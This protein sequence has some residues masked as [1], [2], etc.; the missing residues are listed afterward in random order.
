LRVTIE[1]PTREKLT[2]RLSGK[3]VV[4]PPVGGGSGETSYGPLET[5]VPR[6]ESVVAFGGLASGVWSHEIAVDS[7]GQL[8]HQGDQLVADDGEPALIW[9]RVFAS[10]L[11]V[12]EPDDDGDG[13]CDATC[14]LRD[15][16]ETANGL[17][18]ATLIVFDR[19]AFGGGTV[20]ITIDDP[21]PLLVEAPSLAIDGTD[22]YGRPFQLRPFDQRTY[23]TVISLISGAGEPSED[24]YCPCRE[25][26]AGTFRVRAPDVIF[27]GLEIRRVLPAE[28]EIC[29]G[30]Q[31]LIN[32]GLGSAGSLIQ[33]CRFDGGASAVT[34]AE[35]PAG[36]TGPATGKDC[37][38]SR[39]TE[40]PLDDPVLVRDSE[41]AYCMDRGVKSEDGVM[42]I[43]TSWIHNNLRGGAFA[44]ASDAGYGVFNLGANLFEQNGLN[45]PNE[46]PPSCGGGQVLARPNASEVS[47]Q[48][49][50]T[51]IAADAN[52]LR[53]GALQ[54]LYFQEASIGLLSNLYV[55]GINNADNGKGILI[56]RH[57][58]ASGDVLIRGT[59]VV[60]NDDA[61]VKV[62]D[63]VGAD[64]GTGASPGNNAFTQNGSQPRRDLIDTEDP[65]TPSPAR[66][67]QWSAC[68]DGMNPDADVCFVQE[69]SDQ[70]TN[71]DIG[72][73]NLF[74]VTE[75]QPH[76]SDASVEITSVAPAKAV[77]G[78]VVRVYGA[79]FDAVS[80]HSGGVNGDCRDLASGNTCQPLQG[81]CVEFLHEGQ[82]L[83]TADVL[84]VTPTMVAVRSPI[85][86]SEQTQVRVRRQIL[87]GGEAVSDPVT[88]CVNAD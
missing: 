36:E 82:W 78:G 15:A 1:N 72:G 47:A 88:F 10:V 2:V 77:T 85:F 4:A 44:L 23:P 19:D 46:D 58:S 55:C 3:R 31:D 48:G 73:Q 29:C 16:I 13:M 64:F 87:G 68:Y 84:A 40:A 56:Q 49:D 25:S 32:F 62:R 41:V 59:S 69:I 81:T 24:E 83:E 22:A 21:A 75:P 61:G 57:G 12:N 30:D 86:C 80:G 76:Q 50:E 51:V 37:V 14:T 45:C 60:Y 79:G 6:G 35:T 66:G 54:G 20:E 8:L 70:N 74:D 5:E 26:T 42:Q 52:I 38:A 33:T 65:A 28:A 63:T 67:N 27:R 9:W 7:T 53:D 34:N 71:N 39:F 17:P 43:Q 18:D 11:R